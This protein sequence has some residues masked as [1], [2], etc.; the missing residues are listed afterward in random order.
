MIWK[1][2]NKSR[3]LALQQQDKSVD[4][5]Q[6]HLVC[7]HDTNDSIY[8]GKMKNKQRN[9]IGYYEDAETSYD[10]NWSDDYRE[11]NDSHIPNY[12]SSHHTSSLL[13][14]THLLTYL[15]THSMLGY[16]I[17]RNRDC[18]LYIGEFHSNKYHTSKSDSCF[19][20]SMTT[21]HYAID[22]NVY[23][24]RNAVAILRYAYGSVYKGT[25]C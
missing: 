9:G 3:L 25:S 12:A 1:C 4:D 18:D 19:V 5:G 23:S 8:F 2:V 24:D 6:L 22:K 21:L 17:S 15:L 14:F 11:G 13:L 7:F 10:G 20:S 16:G